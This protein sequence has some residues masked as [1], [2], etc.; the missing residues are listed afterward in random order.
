VAAGVAA[1]RS[2]YLPRESKLLGVAVAGAVVFQAL[3]GIGTLMMQA[4]VGMSI[5]H[6]L[7][8]ALVL[9]LAVAFGWRVRRV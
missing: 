7:V 2:S 8:A 9:S 5:V 4:P 3:L 1:W 6:Q